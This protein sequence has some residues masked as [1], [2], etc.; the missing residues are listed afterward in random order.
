MQAIQG[1]GDMQ[2][3]G[4][5]KC[6]EGAWRHSMNG[7]GDIQQ[8][9]SETFDKVAP[10][11]STTGFGHF[12]QR[13]SETC[14][15]VARRHST[16]VSSAIGLPFERLRGPSL[17]VSRPTLLNVSEPLHC[18]SP[19]PFVECLGAPSTWNVR[20]HTCTMMYELCTHVRTHARTRTHTRTR[21]RGN[22]HSHTCHMQFEYTRTCMW[23]FWF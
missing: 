9:G 11:H 16:T 15:E 7:L 4:S 1:L 3:R 5:E 14:N 2:R 22:M 23:P 8:R 19:S 12:Q 18:T 21:V 10:R 6:N 17:H 20:V 13:G